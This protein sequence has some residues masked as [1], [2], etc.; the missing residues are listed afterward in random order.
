MNDVIK[1]IIKIYK[2]IYPLKEMPRTGW[3]REGLPRTNSDTIA[4][5]SYMVVLISD[6]V[7][8]GLKL[9]DAF[10]NL[11]HLKINRIALYHDIAES[12]TGDID[13]YFKRTFL[14]NQRSKE[15]ISH[16][17]QVAVAYLSKS[18][19]G[20]TSSIKGLLGEYDQ[21][22]SAEAK[23]VKFADCFDAFAFADIYLNKSY[24]IYLELVKKKLLKNSPE[25]DYGIGHC[26]VV[27]LEYLIENWKTINYK[28]DD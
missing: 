22:S 17:E 9:E 16:F 11:D 27:M 23:I 14:N 13:V 1:D 26:L 19:S 25:S 21:C 18:T 6:L 24:T 15:M 3:I 7:C 20:I 8:T 5:H 4:S 12:V 28:D 10:K 2:K